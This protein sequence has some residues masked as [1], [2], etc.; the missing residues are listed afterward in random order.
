MPSWTWPRRSFVDVYYRPHKVHFVSFSKE[1][2]AKID[3]ELRK[4]TGFTAEQF[5]PLVLQWEM[6]EKIETKQDHRQAN[7]SIKSFFDKNA[8]QFSASAGVGF[9]PFSASASYSQQK[10][11]IDTGYF[12]NDEEFKDFRKKN[13]QGEGKEARIVEMGVKLLES[14]TFKSNLHLAA[15]QLLVQPVNQARKLELVS[16]SGSSRPA[17]EKFRAA[18]LK[19]QKEIA[20]LRARLD[21]VQRHLE[22]TASD[23]KVAELKGRIDAHQQQLAAVNAVL[24]IVTNGRFL[25]QSELK[26]NVQCYILNVCG[27][28]PDGHPTIQLVGSTVPAQNRQWRLRFID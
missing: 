28:N 23:A 8:S 26:G 12:K 21:A 1:E 22:K 11:R 14:G 18:A 2:A 9:G 25:I 7:E 16:S 4:G 27:G 6:H 19:Q 17:F 10:E 24:N 13:V 15:S 20:E 3:A 5:K